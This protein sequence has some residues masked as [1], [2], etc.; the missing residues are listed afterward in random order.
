M[1][2]QVL[3]AILFLVFVSPCWA[4][5]Y[6][7]CGSGCDYT[8][9]SAANS[10][11]PTGEH[12]ILVSGTYNETVTDTK[13]GAS[14]GHYRHWLA[15]G[16]VTAYRF[17]ISGN[18]VKIE[19]FTLT[20]YGSSYPNGAVNFSGNGHYFLNNTISIPLN[21]SVDSSGFRSQDVNSTGVIIEGN[22][23]IGCHGNAIDMSGFNH[24]IINNDFSRTMDGNAGQDDADTMDIWGSGY[25]ISGNYIHDYRWS[26]M[27]D[28]SNHIDAIQT[29]Y[30]G[31]GGADALNNSIIE[32]NHFFLGDDSTG[33]LM[34]FHDSGTASVSCFMF[35]KAHDD[36]IRNNI[37]EAANV[38]HC[39]GPAAVNNYNIKYYNNTSRSSLAHK[40]LGYGAG[41]HFDYGTYG[42]NEIYNNIF[43]NHAGHISIETGA[44]GITGDYNIFWNEDSSS[45]GFTNYTPN[46][47]DKNNINPLLESLVIYNTT[48]NYKLQSSSP[49]KD[50]GTNKV[51]DDYN[52]VSRPQGSAY[53]MGAY[54]Y[55]EGERSF[56]GGSQSGGSLR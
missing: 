47:H 39:G 4:T 23:L 21:R 25:L 22:T 13:S 53:D 18:Y 1:M 45:P 11:V 14:A 2:K 17:V 5:T 7:V 46:T 36:T 51:T 56:R 20:G 50:A 12:T 26:D 33:I 24:Q 35:W 10:G 54:E 55:L 16:T 40:A 8:T 30:L 6:T 29:Y 32:K 49:A 37:F 19:G 44:T 31:S 48:T 42:T 52:G 34:P 9:L 41:V 43:I 15:N 3:I 28:Q 27:V 38:F